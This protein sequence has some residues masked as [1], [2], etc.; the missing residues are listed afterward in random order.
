MYGEVFFCSVPVRFHSKFMAVMAFVLVE[1]LLA[2]LQC[3]ADRSSHLHQNAFQIRNIL[4][5]I[6]SN[7]V[8]HHSVAVVSANSTF[9][10]ATSRD[11]LSI[12]MYFTTK[13]G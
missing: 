4:E 1:A 10:L 13:L 6:G 11:Q 12:R 9:F 8:S 5:Q 3:A 7:L 2:S